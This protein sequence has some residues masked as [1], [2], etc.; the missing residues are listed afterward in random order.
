MPTSLPVAWL[1]AVVVAQNEGTCAC[2]VEVGT[3]IQPAGK[4]LRIW[5]GGER[6]FPLLTAFA[7]HTEKRIEV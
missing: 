6:D 5:L 1:S 7:S 3:H 2:Q 4:E